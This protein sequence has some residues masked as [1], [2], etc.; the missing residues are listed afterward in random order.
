MHLGILQLLMKGEDIICRADVTQWVMGHVLS[1]FQ[2][3]TAI[4][5]FTSL[6]EAV[7]Q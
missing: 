6:G 3:T 2:R 5:L 1:R 4:K 7:R